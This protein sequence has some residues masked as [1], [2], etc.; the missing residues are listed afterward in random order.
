MD[1]IRNMPHDAFSPSSGL[2]PFPHPVFE[3]DWR[4]PLVQEW[5]LDALYG[6]CEKVTLHR[7]LTLKA[8]ISS[9]RSISC[10][11]RSFAHSQKMMRVLKQH[12][13]SILLFA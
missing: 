11:T 1:A 8:G 3:G 4:Q 5:H 12:Q 10:S 13:I 9:V 7:A 6:E 2:L